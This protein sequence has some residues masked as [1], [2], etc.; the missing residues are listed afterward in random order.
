MNMTNNAGKERRFIQVDERGCTDLV[1]SGVDRLFDDNQSLLGE[2][3][4]ESN[5]FHRGGRHR[6]KC[7]SRLRSIHR[8]TRS[9]L[10][11]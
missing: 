1:R 8:G 10:E 4:N 9:E 11:G 5:T 6:D 2:E 3:L 7:A